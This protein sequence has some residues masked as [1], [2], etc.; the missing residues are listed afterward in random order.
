M[1]IRKQIGLLT[2]DQIDA[3]VAELLRLHT[4]KP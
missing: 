4:T 2:P 1:I 3:Y